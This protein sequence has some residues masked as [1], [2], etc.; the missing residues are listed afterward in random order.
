MWIIIIITVPAVIF[1]VMFNRLIQYKML[2]QEAWSGI[3]VQLKRRYD[4]IPNIVE[5]VKGY[6][7]HERKV[8]EEVTSIR[9][10]LLDSANAGEKRNLEN[11]LSVGLKSI[12]A[13]A[14]AY[15]DL[16][17]N[18]NFL[19]LQQSLVEVE[20]QLQ[21]AR[22]YY[23]GT[24]RNYN[25]MTGMFPGNIVA[26]LFNFNQADFFEIEYATERKA[27]DVAFGK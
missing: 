12:L 5:A 1:I 9:S 21:M 16:K 10:T 2:M 18:Q 8:L 20:D 6:A 24:A 23:N 11:K 7:G 22:R 27:P 19:A 14:E 4:L 15:P 17:A 13:L 26:K 3:D 25:T